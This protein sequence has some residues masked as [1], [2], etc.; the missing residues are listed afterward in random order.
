MSTNSQNTTENNSVELKEIIA[1]YT[2]HWKWFMLSV[3]VAAICAFIYI[4]YA[5]PQYEVQT[6]ILI[7]EDKTSGSELDVFQDL[8][9]L[10]GGENKVA[11][12]IQIVNSRSNFVEVVKELN[13][14]T[15][16]MVQGNIIETEIYENPPVNLNFIAADSILNKAQFEFFI[17]I[18]SSTTFGYTEEEDKPVKIYAFGKNIDT[19]IGDI[20]ITP[21]VEVFENYKDRKLRVTVRPITD[22]AQIYRNKLIVSNP[23]EFSNIINLSL[24]DPIEVKAKNILNSLI[25]IYNR[26]AVEDKQEVADRTSNFINERIADIST[27]L[28]SVDQSAQDF[29]TEAGVSDIA[30]EANVNLN[31]GVANQQELANAR[32]ELN[33]ASSMQQL[34]DDQDSFEPLPGN[35]LPDGAA[36]S[37]TDKYNTLVL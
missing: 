25:R 26:N 7:L 2:T 19:P 34:V 33:I 15:Q 28:S 30:A 29:K 9:F 8:N 12:E 16:L 18:S 37:A 27:D 10:G 11:D 21:N 1:K 35:M 20:V 23:G 14:N 4:R 6:Q 22:V 5:I 3:I 17:T 36:A 32:N 13:L 31:V 24:A